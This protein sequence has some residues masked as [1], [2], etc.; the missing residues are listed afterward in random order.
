MK[1]VYVWKLVIASERVCP[2]LKME[3]VTIFCHR[4]IRILA[5]HRISHIVLLSHQKTLSL[6]GIMLTM[7]SYVYNVLNPHAEI[8][9]P[10]VNSKWYTT[11][12]RQILALVMS[13]TLQPF[14]YGF[15]NHC[16]V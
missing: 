13:Q 4:N 6:S 11:H 1:N 15:I 9:C 3:S 14:M 8:H 12:T 5:K 10:L 2:S 7:P 16:T